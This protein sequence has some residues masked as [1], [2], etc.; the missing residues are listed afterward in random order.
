MKKFEGILFC[1]DLDG[2]LLR[3]D[4]SISEENLR[5]IE[6]FKSEGGIFTFITGRM[7]CFVADIYNAIRPN[8]PFGCINGG[9]LYDHCTQAYVWSQACP[10]RVL[11]LVA[12]IDEQMPQMGIQVNTLDGIYF[13]KE[14]DA[15]ALFRN[16]TGLP[17]LTCHYRDVPDPIAKIVFGDMSE[18]SLRRLA[19]LLRAHP[20][21]DQFDY[22]RSERILYEILPKGINKATALRKLT[23]HLRISPEKTVAV[24]DYN[25]DVAMLRHAGLGIA[26]ANA[27]P[28]AKEAADTVTVSNEEHAIAKIIWELDR[29]SL[30]V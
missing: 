25:N 19:A 27:V 16:I 4:K 30:R 28:E 22:I 20:M 24:G 13:C 2:T 8:A 23:E 15:M 14:N 7:P 11:D 6:Y 12:W 1:T 9:G 29:G 3:N 21:A 26:V 18:E 17:N 10:R 5:A